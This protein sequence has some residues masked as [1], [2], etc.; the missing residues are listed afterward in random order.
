[1]LNSQLHSRKRMTIVSARAAID[2]RQAV[3]TYVLAFRK[4]CD[5]V[6]QEELKDPL[7]HRAVQLVEANQPVPGSDAHWLQREAWRDCIRSWW[8][9]VRDCYSNPAEIP[10][11][12]I[13]TDRAWDSKHASSLN[14]E[15]ARVICSERRGAT[16]ARA[17]TLIE[18]GAF[19]PLELDAPHMVRAQFET[20]REWAPLE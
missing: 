13:L 9:S 17:A 4:L 14:P 12:W 1:M 11:D 3:G 2:S 19:W 16:W 15:Q 5:A 7:F 18:T 20:L 10:H 8:I 6:W